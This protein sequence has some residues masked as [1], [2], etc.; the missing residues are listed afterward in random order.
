MITRIDRSKSDIENLSRVRTV[1]SPD[2]TPINYKKI[3]VN[4]PWGYEY[5]LFENQYTAIWIL[6]LKPAAQTSMHCHPNKK[7]SLIVL[8]GN[9]V[10][11]MLEGWV[12][13]QKND[14]LIIAPQVFHS[15]KANEASGAM[16]MEIESPP[17]KH[18]LVRL[19]DEYGRQH[20]GYEGKEN[21]S[22]KLHNYEYIDFHSFGK[23]KPK[24]SKKL[25]TC[26]LEIGHHPKLT[27]ITKT[28]EKENAHLFCLLEGTLTNATTS[29]ILSV[30]EVEEIIH[31]RNDQS[32]IASC[33]I[34][35]LKVGSQEK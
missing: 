25:R 26:R 28:L 7:T 10:C 32:I 34:M 2:A 5:L 3:V 4:K 16:L 33:D 17:N 14:C 29:V 27:N 18:D 9:V 24:N 31:L 30:G 15:T 11:S 8:E 19:S 1:L 12:S 21:F 35:Y 6:F 20:Q 22:K 23:K 13:A